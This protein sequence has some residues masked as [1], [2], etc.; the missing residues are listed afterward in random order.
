MKEGII[1][2]EC[3]WLKTKPV[4]AEAI[5]ELN[6]YR[7]KLYSLGLIGMYKK[8]IGYGNISI[9]F[10]DN[11]FIITGS[12]TGGIK[13][14]T[15]EHYSIV[16]S[17]D[18]DKNK[19][20]CRGPIKPSSESLSHAA[21]YLVE[22]GIGAVVHVHSKELWEKLLNK[23]ATTE[24]EAEY[25]TPEMAHKIMSLIRKNPFRKLIVMGGHDGGIITFG[26]N[27]KEAANTIIEHLERIKKPVQ[28]L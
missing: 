3:D 4:Q 18:I 27:L 8:G 23:A 26:S 5:R 19:L 14:L 25:G 24:K 28:N 13:N 9:R 16:T 22:H 20:S 6:E 21:C 1:K 2:F 10:K 7:S 15:P 12:K 11:Q 17:V